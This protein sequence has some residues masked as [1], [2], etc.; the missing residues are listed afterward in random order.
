LKQNLNEIKLNI[1]KLN[2]SLNTGQDKIKEH[3]NSLR[4][5]IHLSTEMCIKQINEMNREFIKAVNTYE[6]DCVE[7]LQQN[8]YKQQ[9]DFIECID[10]LNKFETKWSNYL[11]QID[12][13]EETILKVN[14]QAKDLIHRAEYQMDKLQDFLFN[15]NYLKYERVNKVVLGRFES[16]TRFTSTI[17]SNQEMKELMLMCRFS[18]NQN[19]KLLYR[20]SRDGFGASDF[21][22]KVNDAKNTLTLIKTKNGYIFGGYTR[23]DWSG[24]CFKTDSNAFIFSLKNN[25]NKA[26]VMKCVEDRTAICCSTTCGVIFGNNS[27]CDILICDNSDKVNGSGSNLGSSYPHPSYEFDSDEANSFLA[28]SI[29]FQTLEIETFT[30]C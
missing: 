5:Q 15:G 23:E 2:T 10:D 25:E 17:V 16:R 14:N 11:Q 18:L 12:I 29:Y 19:W 9:D 24:S 27:S 4:A 6:F 26:L 7:A 21:H 3:C 22:L 1:D 8:E 20:A 13:K 28:G 30:K